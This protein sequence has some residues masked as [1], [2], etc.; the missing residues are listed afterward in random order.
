MCIHA[1]VQRYAHTHTQIKPFQ[2]WVPESTVIKIWNLST[3]A[4]LWKFNYVVLALLDLGLECVN[5]QESDCWRGSEG[6]WKTRE[7]G[8]DVMVNPE[9]K[10]FPSFSQILFSS[11]T[12]DFH[13]TPSVEACSSCF[14]SS[15]WLH[16]HTTF[17]FS[18]TG[19]SCPPRNF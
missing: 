10:A 19:A 13:V 1:H 14:P 17:H 7:C 15:S 6:E 18:N 11:Q 3:L 2:N 16:S 4:L 12:F 8:F 9:L 5:A